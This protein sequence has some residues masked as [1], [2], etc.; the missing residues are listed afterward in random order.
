MSDEPEPPE[1]TASA[2]D[3]VLT[4]GMDRRQF[5][6]RAAALGLTATAIPAFL[7]ACARIDATATAPASTPTTA[8]FPTPTPFREAAVTPFPTP[9]ATPAP[10]TPTPALLPTPTATPV[11][12]TPTPTLLPTPTA[13]PAPP[14]PLLASEDARVS[15]LLW[16]AGFGASQ[17][18]L[19]RFRGMGLQATIDHLVDFESVD[20]TALEARL[21]EQDLDLEGRLNHLQRWW[22][23]RM[24]YTERPLQE[25][26][27]LFWHG[28]LTSSFKKTGDG[29]QTL[30]QNQLF[31]AEGMGRYSDLL[32]AVSRDPA[33]MIYLDSRSNKKA[34]PNENYSRE[35]M[36]L[37]S[38]GVGHYSEDDVRES[39][40]AF[41]GWQLR[42][43]TEFF[44]NERQHDFGNKTFL[45]QTGDFDGDDIVDIIMAKPEAAEYVCARLWRFFAYDDPEPAVVARLAAIFTAKN[46]EVRP[47]VRAIFESDEFYSDRAAAA[48]VKAPAELA[49]GAVRTLEISTDFATLDRI[50]EDMGQTLFDPPNV[51]GWPGG[52]AW[53]NSAAL[54]QRV[55]FANAVATARGRRLRF[56]PEQLV[57]DRGV[58]EPETIV[59]FLGDLLLGARLRQTE[60]R[61]LV[62]FVEALNEPSLDEKLRSV[63]YLMLASPDFQL[64]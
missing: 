36:E 6:A 45:G 53:I 43:K 5:M 42:R 48:L 8:P 57:N 55:N 14:P 52:A 59:T 18:E 28:I 13:T 31:R 3:R 40:R 15:H 4:L 60:H 26:I 41:T 16:R 38:L 44:F 17:A 20:D 12:P 32:K 1:Q 46:T 9:T 22:L 47:V 50:I 34:A 37:F 49:A 19:A 24:A 39:A 21:A 58:A 33:M 10:P 63:V 2:Q 27:S 7:A 62:S 23:Q 29:P 64:A 51:A 30:Q 35:L 56:D 54:L 25:K 61:L 11:T